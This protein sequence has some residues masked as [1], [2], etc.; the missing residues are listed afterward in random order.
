M[1]LEFF[2]R[3]KTNKMFNPYQ[4]PLRTTDTVQCGEC[5]G[6]Y[7][8]CSYPFPGLVHPRG[9]F[10]DQQKTK[11]EAAPGRMMSGAAWGGA[12]RELKG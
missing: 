3:F 6:E 2:P 1:Q 7:A 12:Q 4:N 9:K 10:Q 8:I 5:L 11:A